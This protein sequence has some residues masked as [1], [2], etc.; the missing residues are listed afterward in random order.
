MPLRRTAT[1]ALAL[2]AAG[3]HAPADA[4]PPPVL[5]ANPASIALPV[6]TTTGVGATVR[7]LAGPPRFAWRSLA[8][9]VAEIVRTTDV[10]AILVR[11]ARIGTTQLVVRLADRA[12]VADTVEVAVTAPP[13]QPLGMT[14]KPS[15]MELAVGA[16]QRIEATF[17][18]CVGTTTDT[19]VTWRSIQPQVATVDST[20]LVTGVAPGVATIVAASRATPNIQAVSTVTVR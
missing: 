3:C 7:D 16:S 10:G 20:G 11:G 8:P 17:I 5:I 4:G 13:C 1:L 9:D 19:T 6:G 14:V 15:V 2:A 12:D 18:P